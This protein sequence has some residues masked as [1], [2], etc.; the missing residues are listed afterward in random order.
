MPGCGG[1]VTIA[2]RAAT[3]RLPGKTA[4][5][6]ANAPAWQ[7]ACGQVW[8]TAN[9]ERRWVTKELSS[10]ANLA[11]TSWHAGKN[12]SS[13]HRDGPPESWI[14][15]CDKPP[16]KAGCRET[17]GHY[18]HNTGGIV[19]NGGLEMGSSSCPAPPGLLPWRAWKCPSVRP[20]GWKASREGTAESRGWRAGQTGRRSG[21]GRHLVS[22]A[23]R[24]EQSECS[25][26]REE[27][28]CRCAGHRQPAS[29]EA[30]DPCCR[31]SSLGCYVSSSGA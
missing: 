24:E 9:R 26:A 29:D 1:P 22:S 20:E 25:W 23:K 15:T 2:G 11:S 10:W 18:A 12:A 3:R 31:A 7:E 28:S 8:E 30:A 19:T 16:E 6:A 14:S 4:G 5:D 17:C 27:A 21:V 13:G